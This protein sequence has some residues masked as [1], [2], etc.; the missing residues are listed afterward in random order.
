MLVML[1]MVLGVGVEGCEQ[2]GVEQAIVC[3]LVRDC[4]FL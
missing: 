2:V 4:D 1:V 3:E